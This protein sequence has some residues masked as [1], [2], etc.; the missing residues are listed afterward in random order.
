MRRIILCTI[1]AATV[2]LVVGC[3]KSVGI[4]T[5]EY[6]Q[7]YYNSWITVKKEA[8]PEYLWWPISYGTPATDTDHEKNYGYILEDFPG[9]GDEIVDS[10]YLFIEF[11]TYD[12]DGSVLSTTD[13][14][15]SHRTGVDYDPTYYYGPTVLVNLDYYTSVGLK[16]GIDG[17]CNGRKVYDRMKI[18]GRRTMVIPGWLSSS[19]RYSDDIDYYLNNVT[20]T[21][22]IYDFSV[23]DMTDDIE[24]FQIDSI[25]NY[26]LRKYRLRDS[27]YT[28][29]YYKRLDGPRTEVSFS[30][31]TTI[32]INYIGRLL[33]GQ[34]FDT[35]IEDTAK[36]WGLYSAS[37]S[38]GPVELNWSTDSTSITLGSDASSVITGFSSIVTRMNDKETA[39][40]V[41]YSSLGYGSSG[42]GNAIPAYAPLEFEIRIVDEE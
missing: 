18:G 26:C 7:S 34:V 20:G 31:D 5:N 11:T 15:V 8:H 6:A 24:Q 3:A 12:L 4:N 14:E 38:Y 39:V 42:S 10:T 9:D 25:E 37:N 33:N 32:Y 17:I 41:F 22:Y 1:I 30:D 40:G 19:V 27:V 13:R 21:D 35:T 29:F 23:T 16:D 36:V 28:G 2:I